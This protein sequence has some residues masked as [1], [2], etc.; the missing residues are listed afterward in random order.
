MKKNWNDLSDKEQEKLNSEWENSNWY[1]HAMDDS[2]NIKSK[3]T[4]YHNYFILA[5]ISLIIGG[6][7]CIIWM[8]NM[9]VSGEFT[10]EDMGIYVSLIILF[11]VIYCIFGYQANSIEKNEKDLY[12][13]M[14]KTKWLL[15][16]HNIVK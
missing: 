13:D 9:L 12:I 7:I 3:N 5:I 10:L 16:K 1:K 11:V 14:E 8:Y 6:V 15:D 2:K 4:S